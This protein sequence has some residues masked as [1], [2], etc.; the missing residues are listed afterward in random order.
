MI[1]SYLRYKF[2]AKNVFHIHSPFVYDFVTKV[3]NDKTPNTDYDKMY[4]LSR[5]LDKRKHYSYAK[6]RKAKLLY[7]IVRY[8]DPEAML[9][10]GSMTA[11]NMNALALGKMQA[12]VFLEQVPGYLETLNAM[13]VVNV[14]AL[15]PADADHLVSQ[16]TDLVFFAHNAV[17]DEYEGF[18]ADCFNHKTS[19][20]IFIFEGIHRSS[21]AEEI[22]NRVI[23]DED[24]S[25]SI[26]LY[27]IGLIFFR[28][29][30]EKQDF[31][32]K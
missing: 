6:R 30:I 20:S 9:C 19:D 25:L 8:F 18:L 28:V 7:R 15:Q 11:L 12:K 17:Q 1:A 29:G 21:E 4:R 24:V 23:D 5:L 14:C 13:G 31:V 2:Q 32:L 10:V 3:L 16:N 27:H 22:W 26:D